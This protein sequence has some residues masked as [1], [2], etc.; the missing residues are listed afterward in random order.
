MLLT[1]K[2]RLAKDTLW[3]I[4]DKCA[5]KRLF[6]SMKEEV[7]DLNITSDNTLCFVENVTY[8]DEI[9][10]LTVKSIYDVNIIKNFVNLNLAY[11]L[12]PVFENGELTHIQFFR[13]Y[14]PIQSVSSSYPEEVYYSQKAIDDAV[15]QIYSEANAFIGREIKRVMREEGEVSSEHPEIA[16]LYKMFHAIVPIMERYSETVKREENK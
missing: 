4:Q 2:I 8:I 11:N 1:S 7:N 6:V 3:K 14:E 5:E 16:P 12:I 9:L 15:Y 13:V 10:T